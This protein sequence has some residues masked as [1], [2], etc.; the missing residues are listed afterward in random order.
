MRKRNKRNRHGFSRLTSDSYRR[1][2]TIW[3]NSR[4][5]ELDYKTMTGNYQVAIPDCLLQVEDK[6]I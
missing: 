1:F 5:N 6:D 2:L 4:F 3:Y